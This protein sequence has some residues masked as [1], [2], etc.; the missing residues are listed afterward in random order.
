MITK[1]Y[2]YICILR[3]ILSILSS[4]LYDKY[5]IIT[6]KNYSSRKR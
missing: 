6:I 1:K 4:I 2:I 3:M 5:D